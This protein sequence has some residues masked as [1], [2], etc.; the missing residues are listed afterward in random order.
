[1]QELEEVARGSGNMGKLDYE[2]NEYN[3]H[4]SMDLTSAIAGHVTVPWEYLLSDILHK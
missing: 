3:Q 1:M 2:D 4:T